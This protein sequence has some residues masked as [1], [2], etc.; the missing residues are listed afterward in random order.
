M[1]QIYGLH[2]ELYVR[3][4]GDRHTLCAGLGALELENAPG[5]DVSE[6]LLRAGRCSKLL[7][8]VNVRTGRQPS[9][10]GRKAKLRAATR[11]LPR[12]QQRYVTD[13]CKRCLAP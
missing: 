11:V 4:E 13:L 6:C 2:A 12:S 10:R 8:G 5:A 9:G 7:A 1:R 3:L